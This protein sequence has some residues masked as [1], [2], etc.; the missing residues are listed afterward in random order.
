MAIHIPRIS[1]QIYRSIFRRSCI[2]N[3]PNTKLSQQNVDTSFSMPNG[4][5]TLADTHTTP[6]KSLI[7]KFD[8]PKVISFTNELCCTGFCS[9]FRVIKNFAI[10]FLE[11]KSN[12]FLEWEEQNLY[13]RRSLYKCG[14][15]LMELCSLWNVIM[16]WFLFLNINKVCKAINFDSDIGIMLLDSSDFGFVYQ[17]QFF[18]ISIIC[19]ATHRTHPCNCKN[20]ETT[21]VF[22]TQT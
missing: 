12:K 8:D 22:S 4:I 3:A 15:W 9:I 10:I 2:G 16:R 20:S 17:F 1:K 21:K 6:K 5:R 18:T 14:I 13:G 11:V 19:L 7:S